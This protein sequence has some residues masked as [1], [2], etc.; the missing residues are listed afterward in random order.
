[1]KKKKESLTLLGW[2]SFFLG[3][4][5]EGKKSCI[6]SWR[7]GLESEHKKERGEKIIWFFF[8]RV[9][10]HDQEEKVLKFNQERK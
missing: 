4:E 6:K 10:L 3:F 5:E 7:K 1:M 2:P 8:P 9:N